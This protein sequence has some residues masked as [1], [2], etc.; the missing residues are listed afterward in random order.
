MGFTAYGDEF[1]AKGVSQGDIYKSELLQRQAEYGELKATQVGAQLT[2]NLGVTLGNI[3]AIRAA[4]RTDPT[5]PTGAAVRGCA[6]ATGIEQRN[7]QVAS[8]EQQARE[9]EANAA[10]LRYASGQALLAGNVSAISDILRGT[11]RALPGLGGLGG[12][13]AGVNPDSIAGRIAYAGSISWSRLRGAHPL[14]V[15]IWS[16][17]YLGKNR[18]RCIVVIGLSVS[19]GE[20]L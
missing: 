3:D 17:R 6:E 20:R 13:G 9:D 7:I 4:A 2:R 18:G 11:A 8:I 19:S 1:K 12:G 5:S 14:A 10:Y 15:R 16:R